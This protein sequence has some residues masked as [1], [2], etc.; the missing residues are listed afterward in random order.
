MKDDAQKALEELE[1]QLLTDDIAADDIVDDYVIPDDPVADGV[2]TDD[3]LLEDIINEVHAQQEMSLSETD[4]QPPETE[5]Q[6]LEPDPQ[7]QTDALPPDDQAAK[8]VDDPV[9]IILMFAASGLALGVSILL[10]F[11]L[12][13][14]L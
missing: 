2:I 1:E 7:T 8:R 9:Q 10:I 12:V 13:N 6:P 14:Y 3:A 4:E 11:W 5:E